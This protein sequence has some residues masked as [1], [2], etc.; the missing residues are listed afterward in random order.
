MAYLRVCKPNATSEVQQI[1]PIRW[2]QAR[3]ELRSC[4]PTHSAL[5]YL[6]HKQQVRFNKIRQSF[7]TDVRMHN[8][9][10]TGFLIICQNCFFMRLPWKHN[11][12][13]NL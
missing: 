5:A 2:H 6:E 12:K 13:L 8:L 10:T 9:T 1:L 3:Q 4:R 7:L 11:N